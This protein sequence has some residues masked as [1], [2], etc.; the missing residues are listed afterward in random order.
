MR[1]GNNQIP[2]IRQLIT[3]ESM[4]FQIRFF[5]EV[6]IAKSYFLTGTRQGKEWNS[7]FGIQGMKKLSSSIFAP[8]FAIKGDIEVHKKPTDGE[9]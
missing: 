5:L 8:F 2:L 4:Q 9:Q 3:F 1:E 7:A 6:P